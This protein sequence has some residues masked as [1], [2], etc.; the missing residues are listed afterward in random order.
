VLEDIVVGGFR[1]SRLWFLSGDGFMDDWCLIQPF[2]LG[3]KQAQE[4]TM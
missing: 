1:G 2:I 3:D 4:K